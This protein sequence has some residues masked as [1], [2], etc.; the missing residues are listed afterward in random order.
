MFNAKDL[1]FS[2]PFLPDVGRL[3]GAGKPVWWEWCLKKCR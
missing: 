2:W 3:F 1:H